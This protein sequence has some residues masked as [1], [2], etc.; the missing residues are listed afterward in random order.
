MTEENQTQQ[1]N[2][3]QPGTDVT[4]TGATTNNDIGAG[5]PGEGAVSNAVSSSASDTPSSADP[6]QP[7]ASTAVDPVDPQAGEAG[8]GTG[9]ANSGLTNVSSESGSVSGQS[10]ATSDS[11]LTPAAASSSSASGDDLGNVDASSAA[12]AATTSTGTAESWEPPAPVAVD[13]HPAK[14]HL[15]ALRRKIESGEAI[16]MADLLALIHRIEEAL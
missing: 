13:E 2:A 11:A 1:D 5:T 6:A 8:N 14:P 15:S 7:G 3:G 4:N 10:P 9:I 12:A 16:I